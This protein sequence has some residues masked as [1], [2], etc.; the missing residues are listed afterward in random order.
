M[1]RE[2]EKRAASQGVSAVGN[3]WWCCA[4]GSC[5]SILAIELRRLLMRD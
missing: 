5:R 4:R 3:V 1:R 2:Q